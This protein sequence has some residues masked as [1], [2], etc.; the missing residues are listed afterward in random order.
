MTAERLPASLQQ[1]HYLIP[2]D[3]EVRR[4]LEAQ[5]QAF[6][7]KRVTPA[8]PQFR[9]TFERIEAAEPTSPQ[10]VLAQNLSRFLAAYGNQR[11]QAGSRRDRELA[12]RARKD[13]LAV[14]TFHRI[15]W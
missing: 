8:T 1:R 6:D 4:Y 15:S 14:L 3:L 11:W 2:Q 5:D 13:A 10:G 12:E 9:E 7:L